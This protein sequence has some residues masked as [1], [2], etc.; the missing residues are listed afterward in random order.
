MS[1]ADFTLSRLVQEFL[2]TLEENV[3]LY[4]SVPPSPVRPEF[5]EALSET[6]SLALNI[7]T[8]KARSEYIIAPILAEL[9]RLAHHQIG[10][11]SGIDFTVDP[12]RGLAGICDFIIC[13]SAEQLYVSAPVIL[14]AE[15][16]NEDM[17][18]GYAQCI[19]EML[20]AQRFNEQANIPIAK[21]YGAVTIG[22]RWKFLE[23]EN[24]TV[25][26][27]IADYYLHDLGKILGILLHMATP[28]DL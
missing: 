7:S 21:I 24:S 15:A 4:A 20:A 16:K 12:S 22:E 14:L 2:L 1:Y 3:N 9:W 27:D 28:I 11:F 26:I 23:I 13:Q 5:E 6:T 10:L 8:E 19:A 17:K 25:R 18:R